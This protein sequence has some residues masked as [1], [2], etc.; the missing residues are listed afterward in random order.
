MSTYEFSQLKNKIAT[1]F[2]YGNLRISH[3]VS[4]NSLALQVWLV[5]LRIYDK[6]FN[7]NK[8]MNMIDKTI[9]TFT[10][11]DVKDKG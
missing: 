3:F 1:T 4:G 10:K 6:W 5:L 8:I 2:K 9:E 7:E 11:G